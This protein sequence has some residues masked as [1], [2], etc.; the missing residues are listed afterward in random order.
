MVEVGETS[1]IPFTLEY[2][3]TCDSGFYDCAGVCDGDAV[4][5]ECGICD[6]DGSSCACPDGVEAQLIVGGGNG[7]LKLVGHC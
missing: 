5:D 2:P 3:S 7:T 1:Q 6:G 4:V